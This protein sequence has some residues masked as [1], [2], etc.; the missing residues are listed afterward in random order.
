MF[1]IDKYYLIIKIDYLFNY[2]FSKYL[3]MEQIEEQENKGYNKDT[4]II[5]ALLHLAFMNDMASQI[6]KYKLNIVKN[7][8]I[9]YFSKSKLT[10]EEFK[11][12]IFKNKRP[13]F[14]KK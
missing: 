5:N 7:I 4:N 11:K 8:Y 12:S 6:N 13:D 10:Y 3:S 9:K 1:Y 2:R 14:I